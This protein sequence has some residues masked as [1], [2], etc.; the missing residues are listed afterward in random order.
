MII[1]IYKYCCKVTLTFL[2]GISIYSGGCDLCIKKNLN[3][4]E[5]PGCFFNLVNDDLSNVKEFTIEGFVRFVIENK[6]IE[7]NKQ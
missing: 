5:I 1:R 7:N 6:K 2:T 3:A 4:R